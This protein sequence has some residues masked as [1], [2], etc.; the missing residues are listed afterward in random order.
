MSE[1]AAS[2]NDAETSLPTIPDKP[3]IVV[4]GDM[5]KIPDNTDLTVGPGLVYENGVIRCTK[6]GVIRSNQKSVWID[7][8]NRR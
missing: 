5:F 7:R 3:I 6:P 4:C 2:E 8:N 1:A